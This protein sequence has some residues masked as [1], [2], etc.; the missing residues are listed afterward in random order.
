LK[1]ANRL[2]AGFEQTPTSPIKLKIGCILPH[3]SSTASERPR[4]SVDI[5]SCVGGEID[6]NAKVQAAVGEAAVGVA[7]VTRR[8]F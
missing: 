4:R 8:I 1:P 3:K 6:G 7:R 5:A 2:F